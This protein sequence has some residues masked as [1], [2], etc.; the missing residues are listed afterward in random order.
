MNNHVIRIAR[1][2][3]GQ[4]VDLIT[5]LLDA[6]EF[7]AVTIGFG[8][9]AIERFNSKSDLRSLEKYRGDIQSIIWC[10]YSPKQT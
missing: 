5:T 8:A 2:T 9:G 4:I 3:D 10:G 7:T 1:L 6:L